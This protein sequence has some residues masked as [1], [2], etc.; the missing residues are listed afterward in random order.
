[1]G[2]SNR[3]APAGIAASAIFALSLAGCAGGGQI[4]SIGIA[5]LDPAKATIAITRID[6]PPTELSGQFST[7]LAEEAKARGFVVVGESGPNPATRINAYLDATRAADGRPAIA[8]VINAYADRR[9]SRS[10]GTVPI[11]PRDGS[12]WSGL[13]GPT[14]RRIAGQGLDDLSR[15]LTTGSIQPPSPASEEPQ[16]E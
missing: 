9:L 11:A 13:D 14:M 3:R 10:S 4:A 1:M 5:A 16:P 8:F 12:P 15:V 7:V 6:G 2:V